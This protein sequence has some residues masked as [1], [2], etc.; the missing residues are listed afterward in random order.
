[1]PSSKHNNYSVVFFAEGADTNCE[2]P[3]HDFQ[4]LC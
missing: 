4:K 1:M 2:E 3:M